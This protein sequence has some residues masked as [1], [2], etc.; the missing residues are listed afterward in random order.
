MLGGKYITSTNKSIVERTFK[1][2]NY[3]TEHVQIVYT[4]R[5]QLKRAFTSKGSFMQKKRNTETAS[6]MSILSL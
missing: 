3:F 2:L 1:F 6:K 5:H 4:S